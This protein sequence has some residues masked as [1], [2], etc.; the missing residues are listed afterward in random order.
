VAPVA[1]VAPPA[2]LAKISVRIAGW[3]VFKFSLLSNWT[4]VLPAAE[5]MNPK[6]E[7]GVV[8]HP[9]TAAVAS[10]VRKLL[11]VVVATFCATEAPSP[12]PERPVTVNSLQAP[13]A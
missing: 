4:L 10:T 13:L 7:P 6:F 3:L 8:I 2:P 12:G 9:C 1:P 11:T 5:M